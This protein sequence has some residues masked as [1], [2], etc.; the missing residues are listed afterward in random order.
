MQSTLKE[1]LA[2]EAAQ[3]AKTAESGERSFGDKLVSI[4]DLPL[5]SFLQG[6]LEPVLDVIR[7]S[8]FVAGAFALGL[9]SIPLFI[10]SSVLSKV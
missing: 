2:K 4:F 9:A 10:L 1:K 3:E 5:L 7:D 8:T 6:P